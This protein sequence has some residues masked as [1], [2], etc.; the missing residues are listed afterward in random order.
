MASSGEGVVLSPAEES[1]LV[2]R[3]I[4]ERI[5]GDES[6]FLW[7]DYPKLSEGTFERVVNCLGGYRQTVRDVLAS[8][9]FEDGLDAEHIYDVATGG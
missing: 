8:V 9:E 6:W 4:I 1:A 3:A 7:E 2:L 5:D